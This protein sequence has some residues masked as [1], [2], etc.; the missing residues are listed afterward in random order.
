[1]L[2]TGRSLLLIPKTSFN[3]KHHLLIG[4]MLGFWVY[5]FLV[6]VGPYDAQPLSILWRAEAMVGYGLCMV[7]SYYAII[8]LQ[9]LINDSNKRGLVGRE[10][11]MTS[12]LF[13]VGFPTSYAYYK[14]TIINGTYSLHSYVWQIY[15]P[16][17]LILWPFALALRG[18]ARKRVPKVQSSPRNQLTLTGETQTDILHV[19]EA[20]L[21]CVKSAGNY[22]EVYFWGNEALQ[23]K[24]LRT[25]TKR[26]REQVPSLVQTHRSFFV[27]PDWFRQWTGS[28]ALSLTHMEVPVS[29]RF[30]K[31]LLDQPP[32]RP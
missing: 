20:D 21:I 12:L 24:L 13:V 18:M 27:N 32:F 3:L 25:S 15:L 28:K 11:L 6:L 26:I 9:A 22:V 30:R 23:K 8:P 29:D 7:I 4:L 5:G 10:F 17:I 31:K 2:T 14:S 1:M 16:T 19:N